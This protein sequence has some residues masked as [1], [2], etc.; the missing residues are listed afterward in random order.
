MHPDIV[1]L[2]LIDQLINIWVCED[3]RL[4]RSEWDG[5]F[6]LPTQAFESDFTARGPLPQEGGY[7]TVVWTLMV[8]HA[9]WIQ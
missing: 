5:Q 4:N 8:L 9:P 7:P 6:N 2:S 3:E 1:R